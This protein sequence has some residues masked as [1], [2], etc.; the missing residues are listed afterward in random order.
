MIGRQAL[1]KGKDEITA[2]APG[3][4]ATSFAAADQLANFLVDLDDPGARSR[5]TRRAARD[6]GRPGARP[7]T[8]ASRASS[9]TPTTRRWRST[10]STTIGHLLH[11]ILYEFN[12]GPCGQYNASPR[13]PPR[14]AA[15]TTSAAAKDRC[16]AWIGPNQPQINQPLAA[17]PV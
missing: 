17:P 7:A 3:H 14:A 11:F 8:R 9:T 5:S 12:A 1:H 10:S 2:A 16:V 15:E 6:T 4:A 13:C